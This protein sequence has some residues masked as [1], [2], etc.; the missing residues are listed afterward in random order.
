MQGRLTV[1]GRRGL[2]LLRAMTHIAGGDPWLDLDLS[3]IGRALAAPAASVNRFCL[4]ACCARCCSAGTP[5]SL[6]SLPLFSNL[7]PPREKAFAVTMSISSRRTPPLVF[8]AWSCL[9]T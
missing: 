9:G 7:N 1:L 3:S 5:C 2:I 4:D 8:N 6:G